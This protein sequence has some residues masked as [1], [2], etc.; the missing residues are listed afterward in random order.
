[1]KIEY[2]YKYKAKQV[3]YQWVEQKIENKYKIYPF[4]AQTKQAP[5]NHNLLTN[6]A[7]SLRPQIKIDNDTNSVRNSF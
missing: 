7:S 3:F 1:M 4:F 2:K 6:F 5:S